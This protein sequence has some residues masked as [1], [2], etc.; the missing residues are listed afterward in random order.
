MVSACGVQLITVHKMIHNSLLAQY[1]TIVLKTN[2][3]TNVEYYGTHQIKTIRYISVS[4]N[5]LYHK[6]ETM[7]HCT[8]WIITGYKISQVKIFLY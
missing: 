4:T 6:Y 8:K 7:E 3:A 2:P 5:V 1:S